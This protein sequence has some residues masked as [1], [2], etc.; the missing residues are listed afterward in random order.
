LD[1]CDE[2]RRCRAGESGLG[3]AAEAG[4]EE[5]LALHAMKLDIPDDDL[6]LI[7]KALDH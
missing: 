7:V 1:W 4:S 3:K 6:E 5:G 2:T